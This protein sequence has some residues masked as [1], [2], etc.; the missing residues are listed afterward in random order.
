[1]AFKIALGLALAAQILAALLALR[2]NH[3]YRAQRAWLFISGAAILMA[4]L[5]LTSLLDVWHRTDPVHEDPVFWTLALTSLMIS[6]LMLAGMALLEPLFRQIA[7][8]Q[9]ILRDENK[10]LVSAVEATAAEM[11]LAKR[12]QQNLLPERAPE[13]AR[14]Q[15]AGASHPAEWT[16]GDYYDYFHLAN[17]DQ[18]VLVADASGHGTGP[19]LLMTTTR[20]AV[21]AFATSACDVGELMSR[22]N[23]ALCQDIDDSR[24]VTAFLVA[25]NE[26]SGCVH[27]VGAGHTS[28][29]CRNSGET[30]E[31]CPEHP[32]L[33]VVNGQ[34]ITTKELPAL[35]PGEVL[36]LMSDGILETESPNGEMLGI[37][38]VLRLVHGHHQDSAAEI[39]ER[40]FALS[41]QFADGPQRDDN[42]VVIIKGV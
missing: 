31:L 8:A 28:W 7:Q 11:Q 42:T 5:R 16:S 22:V 25:I 41:D 21:R 36:V 35:E 15:I 17:G 19:A 33:G 2:L 26:N 1:M 9:K 13:L 23:H 4:L 32:P 27:W 14:L 37:E 30:V 24:F 6:L 40:I 39:V 29:L 18:G 34:P 38:P 10:Q 20:A 3:L 12:I